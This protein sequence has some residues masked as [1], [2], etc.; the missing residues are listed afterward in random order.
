MKRLDRLHDEEEPLRWYEYPWYALRL[1]AWHLWPK[2]GCTYCFFYRG[3]MLGVLLG[4]VLG[5]STAWL[6]SRT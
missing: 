5:G 6:L 4:I 2:N 1:F 3:V